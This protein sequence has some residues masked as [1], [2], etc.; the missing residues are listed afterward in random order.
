MEP[1]E[2]CTTFQKIFTII[3]IFLKSEAPKALY[4]S[5][6]FIV[7]ALKRIP[8]GAIL[9]FARAIWG[10]LGIWRGLSRAIWGFARVIW[11]YFRGSRVLFGSNPFFLV[12]LFYHLS[13][14]SFFKRKIEKR[15]LV[16]D[17][18]DD[19]D[20]E[21]KGHFCSGCSIPPPGDARGWVRGYGGVGSFSI[22]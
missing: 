16:S 11:G 17:D 8:I 1:V 22:F 2:E 14:I 6:S 5:H 21:Y 20:A 4:S 9:G 3:R 13:F 15:N 12:S 19:E 18:S 7:S 10:Y